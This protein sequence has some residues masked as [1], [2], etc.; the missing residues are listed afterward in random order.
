MTQTNGVTNFVRGYKTNELSHQRIV[1]SH[2]I[3]TWIERTALDHV[4]VAEQLHHVVIPVDVAFHDLPTTR[5]GDAGTTG[6]R[7]I[8]G[9][10]NDGRI[11]GIIQTPGAVF[12]LSRS[13]F[14]EDGIF[15]ARLLKG[16]FPIIHTLHQIRNPFSRCCRIDVEND[17]LL[18]FNQFTPLVFL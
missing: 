8:G 7:N 13:A 2:L 5:I 18:G 10:I 1:E 14:G 12:F 6:I 11:T 16:Y 3:R 9:L 15:K 17:G 4:P